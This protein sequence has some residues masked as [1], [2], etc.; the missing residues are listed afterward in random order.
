MQNI[1]VGPH[2]INIGGLTD[3][4]LRNLQRQLEAACDAV[5]EALNR[6]TEEESCPN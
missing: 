5:E 4:E 3:A 2:V 1:Y 6:E